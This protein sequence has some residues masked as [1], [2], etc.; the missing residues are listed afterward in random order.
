MARLDWPQLQIDFAPELDFLLVC[1]SARQYRTRFVEYFFET[2]CRVRHPS[3]YFEYFVDHLCFQ[4]DA[5]TAFAA[6]LHSMR[7]GNTSRA[8]LKSV[9]EMLV[10]QVETIGRNL[11]L[12][13]NIKEFMPPRGS[14]GLSL[15]IDAD[16]DLFVN[17]LVSSVE[18][19]VKDLGR[20]ELENVN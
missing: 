3:G 16:Y 18:E 11:L 19:F 5:F 20:V 9:G 4:S 7:Q 15:S 6:E 10:F 13:L 2:R 12:T 17:K 1:V 8:A 14:A